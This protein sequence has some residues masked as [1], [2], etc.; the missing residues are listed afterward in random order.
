[1]EIV[2]FGK[3]VVILKFNIYVRNGNMFLH[4]FNVCVTTFN[5]KIRRI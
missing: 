3:M 4:K 5:V 2:K 1:M